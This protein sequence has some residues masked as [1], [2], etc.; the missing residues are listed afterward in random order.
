MF[1][2]KFM[3]VSGGVTVLFGVLD[4]V[5]AGPVFTAMCF[6]ARVMEAAVIAS[7]ILA[8][9]FPNNV[10][11]VLGCLETFSWPWTNV[12]ASFRWLFVSILCLRGAIYLIHSSTVGTPQRVHFT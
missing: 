6:L 8:K 11:Q 3:C 12:R 9:P 5:S 7:S 1:V 4:P 2:A 10:A